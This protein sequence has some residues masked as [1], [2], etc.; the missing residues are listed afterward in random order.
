MSR[1]YDTIVEAMVTRFGVERD[2]V[3]PET[4]LE[5]LAMDSLRGS[6]EMSGRTE[7]TKSAK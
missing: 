1:V 3:R 7:L 6:R 5:E 2:S 4:A